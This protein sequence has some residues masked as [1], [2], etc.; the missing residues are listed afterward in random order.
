MCA[1]SLSPCLF[2]HGERVGVRGSQ[3]RWSKLLPLTLT[4]SPLE[5]GERERDA[6]HFG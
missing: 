4:L 1:G 6:F 2:R 5:R 3:K